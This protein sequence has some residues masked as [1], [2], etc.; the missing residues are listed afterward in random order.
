MYSVYKIFL[1]IIY[2]NVLTS[3]TMQIEKTYTQSM[4]LYDEITKFLFSI[5][6]C[7]SV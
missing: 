2:L 7:K 3:K 5:L 4:S 1:K 6:F